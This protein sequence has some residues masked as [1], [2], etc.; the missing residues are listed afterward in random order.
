MYQYQYQDS[1]DGWRA[2]AS[3]AICILFI[4]GIVFIPL[5][6]RMDACINVCESRGHECSYLI[7]D[8]CYC[9]SDSGLYNPKDER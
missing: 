3:L 8:G 6:C 2:F 9:V 1:S 4:C 7:G 5:K